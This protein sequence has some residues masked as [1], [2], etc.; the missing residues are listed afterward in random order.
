VS[1]FE[2]GTSLIC[3]VTTTNATAK[4]AICS[5]ERDIFMQNPLFLVSSLRRFLIKSSFVKYSF[6]FLSKSCFQLNVM[7]ERLALLLHI[8]EFWSS[9]I[10]WETGYPE[11]VFMIFLSPQANISD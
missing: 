8:R 10:N 4:M 5:V 11:R 7:V 3:I 2:R 1:G 6:L 9:I